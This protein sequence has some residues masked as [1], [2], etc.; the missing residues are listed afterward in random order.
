MTYQEILENAKKDIGKYCKACSIC[1]G[2][3]CGNQIPGPGPVG[4]DVRCPFLR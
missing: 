3:A 1:N 4:A 2:K